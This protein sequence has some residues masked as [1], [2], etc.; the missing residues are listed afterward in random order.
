MN[1]SKIPIGQ[2]Q[3]KKSGK[4]PENKNDLD[5]RK[6]EE[7]YLKGNDVTHNKKSVESQRTGIKIQK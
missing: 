2:K 5:S 3:T 1:K 7:D 4:P 6:H